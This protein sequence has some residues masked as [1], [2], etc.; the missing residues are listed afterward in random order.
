MAKDAS[1]DVVSKVDMQE[2]DNAVNQASKEM[3]SRF[4]FKGSKSSIEL[5]EEEIVL[6][7]DDEGKLRS[8][9]DILES[10]IIKRGISLKSLNYGKVE[11][12]AAGT[13]RQS[14]KI[15]QGID[16]DNA[17]K[18]VKLIKDSKI[19]VQASVQGDAVRVSGK[20]RD[21]L[22]AVIQL[23]KEADVPVDLQFNNYR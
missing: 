3:T 18:I 8:V 20:S 13:V 21:D 10:K 2:L 4:D 17:K 14:V 12:A 22:Q 6:A 7:S 9:V 5:K 15:K 16:Q 19:K 1:F 11:P 23:L